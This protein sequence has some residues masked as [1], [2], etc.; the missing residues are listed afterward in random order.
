MINL[1]YG[2]GAGG[3]YGYPGLTERWTSGFESK[4]ILKHVGDK[5]DKTKVLL[6]WD[7][8]EKAGFFRRHN[9]AGQNRKQQ[10]KIT[11]NMR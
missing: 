1:K 9:N 2:V 7:N 6:L 5:N 4:L 10:G 8:H 11:P 3:L